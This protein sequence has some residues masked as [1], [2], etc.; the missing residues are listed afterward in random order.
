MPRDDFRNEECVLVAERE[1]TERGEA[2]ERGKG[3]E[4][5]LQT[6]S[7]KPKLSPGATVPPRCRGIGLVSS[8]DSQI[9][10]SVLT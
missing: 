3:A 7:R 10:S 8:R 5:G 1:G 9:E 4:R 2:A 6:L